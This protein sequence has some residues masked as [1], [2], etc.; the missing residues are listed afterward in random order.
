MSGSHAEYLQKAIGAVKQRKIKN[1][2]F[3][4]C[5][6]S[7]A[8]MINQ[9][10]ILDC[11]TEI[12]AYVLNS[13]E[14]IHRNP[15]ALGAESLVLT[16][17]HSGNTPETVAA[18]KFARQKG[19]LTVAYSFKDDSPLWQEAEYG[20]HYDWGPESNAYDHRAGMALRFIFGL[21]QA[22]QPQPKYEKA[23]ESLKNLNEIF[24]RNKKKFAP[25]AEAFGSGYKREP[26]IYT[27][28]SGPL[29]GEAY[30]FAICL[31]QE[32]LWVHSAAIHSGEYFH[33]PFEI[34]DY[35]VP[36]LIF[37]TAGETRPLDERAVKFVQ[38]YSKRVV[39]VDAQDFDWTGMDKELYPYLSAPIMGAVIRTYAERLSEHK[40]HPLSVRRYMWKMEY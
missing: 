34:T 5:G 14:F 9:Q 8:Y 17:S 28:G 38:K 36:F 22:L 19:A 29:Y 26:V 32:M 10:Y 4:A 25:Q 40:G 39:L 15:K 18:A 27:M 2:Y 16:C 12:P 37:K 24:E 1:V 20:L 13:N 3:V 7:L 21:L 30:S 6:G 11:E 35:D 31:L 33:G 23:L